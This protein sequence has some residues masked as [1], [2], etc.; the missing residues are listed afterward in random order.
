M[1]NQFLAS[2]MAEPYIDERVHTY[3]K[4]T[5]KRSVILDIASGQGYLSE[6]LYQKG[7]QHL[8]AADL[9]DKNFKLNKKIFH[10]KQVDA[11]QTLPYKNNY[12]D[13]VIS[14]ETIEHL[15]NPHHFLQEVSRI[16]K[17]KGTFILTTPNVT[18]IISRIYFLIAGRLA[19]HTKN[20]YLLSGHIA[21]LPDWLLKEF[22]N[23]TSFKLKSQTYSSFYLPIFKKRFTRPKFL[24][25]LFGWITIYKLVKS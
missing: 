16:L 23:E 11:N 21:I 22:F 25:P 3:L 18:G 1:K 9:D 13:V 2:P 14:S 5:S 10:F 24:N 6:Q 7:Y 19:F 15:K 8:Y 20:D 12:F 4:G 17:P